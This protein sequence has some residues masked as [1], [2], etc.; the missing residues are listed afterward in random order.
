MKDIT[1]EDFIN[2][3]EAEFPEI[4][5]GKLKPDT[6]FRETMEWDSVNALTFVVLVNIEYDVTL[7]A[8]E[9]VNANTVQDVF[10]IVKKKIEEKENALK[11]GLIKPEPTEEESRAIFGA[12][13]KKDVKK[14][15]EKS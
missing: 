9:F 8:D 1:I 11:K 3:I 7:I 2:K 13:I 5:Q 15:S 10:N 14:E 6:N 12:S 4:S